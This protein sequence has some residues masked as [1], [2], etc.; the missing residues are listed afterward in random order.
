MRYEQAE[1]ANLFTAMFAGEL[2]ANAEMGMISILSRHLPEVERNNPQA[3][4]EG[5]IDETRNS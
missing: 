5:E 4:T 1:A 3:H 2:T